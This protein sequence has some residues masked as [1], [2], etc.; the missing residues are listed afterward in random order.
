MSFAE[1]VELIIIEGGNLSF[2]AKV[3]LVQDRD[4]HSALWPQ[5]DRDLY[6][7]RAALF[8]KHCSRCPSSTAAPVAR[9][10]RAELMP[11]KKMRDS[12][13]RKVLFYVVAAKKMFGEATFTPNELATVLRLPAQKVYRALMSLVMLGEIAI[14]ALSDEHC[15]SAYE[16]QYTV[17]IPALKAAGDSD[18][19]KEA[20]YSVEDLVNAFTMT[21]YD[22]LLEL[23]GIDDT[24]GMLTK[25]GR[26]ELAEVCRNTERK[27]S[28]RT[29]WRQP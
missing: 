27:D 5:T 17:T 23:F 16:K 9:V 26:D 4:E 6:S 25:D 18:G 19:G 15:D 21:Y 10:S 2:R 3:E 11:L 12:V 22:V 24:V 13:K 1:A 29:P 28:N 7:A 14:T 8:A 20:L